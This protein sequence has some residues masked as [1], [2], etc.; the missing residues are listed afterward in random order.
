MSMPN[1]A[2]RAGWL[3]RWAKELSPAR[4]SEIKE[5]LVSEFEKR[6]TK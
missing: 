5:L 2:F 1:K 6:R 4:I 3:D